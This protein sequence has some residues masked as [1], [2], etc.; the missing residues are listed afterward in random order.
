MRAEEILD[1]VVAIFVLLFILVPMVS[2]IFLRKKVPQHQNKIAKH[3]E[4]PKEKKKVNA[5]YQRKGV[6]KP[7]L[8]LVKPKSL[9]KKTMKYGTLKQAVILSEIL[10]RPYSED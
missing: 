4:H 5:H 7:P 3:H 2:S 10:K 6:I 1:W 9:T 8:K